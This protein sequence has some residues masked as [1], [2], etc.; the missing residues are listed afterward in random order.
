MSVS[1]L[2]VYILS[3]TA[4]GTHIMNIC[5][6]EMKFVGVGTSDSPWLFSENS[7]PNRGLT[8]QI[9]FL[10]YLVICK[11]ITTFI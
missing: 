11:C 9:F 6:D 4:P 2:S 8:N 5:W 7:P 10:N 3:S 1:S